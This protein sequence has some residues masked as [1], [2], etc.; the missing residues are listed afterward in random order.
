MNSI[1]LSIFLVLLL[2]VST[3]GQT[4]GGPPPAVIDDTADDFGTLA[5]EFRID[6]DT[7]GS[8]VTRLGGEFRGYYLLTPDGEPSTGGV[9]AFVRAELGFSD[10]VA[11][12]PPGTSID[13]VHFRLGGLVLVPMARGSNVTPLFTFGNTRVLNIAELAYGSIEA[14]APG[15]GIAST[16]EDHSLVVAVHPVLGVAMRE[17]T[18]RVGWHDHAGFEFIA[19][20]GLEAIANIDDVLL[21]DASAELVSTGENGPSLDTS[22][23]NLMYSAEAG[24]T[25][26]ISDPLAISGRLRVSDATSED[27]RID[28]PVVGGEA[29]VVLA[30]ALE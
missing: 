14:P 6:H 30:G 5:A 12:G 28:H 16:G 8:G 3:W 22:G 26:R 1:R 13:R 9:G 19:G 17:S 23:P 15:L 18:R 2:P 20:V 11:G 29:G 21:L 4:S 7:Y 24:A 10:R 25:I 27:R